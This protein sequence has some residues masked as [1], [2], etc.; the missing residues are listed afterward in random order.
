MPTWPSSASAGQES[1]AAAAAA[2]PR[3]AS[4]ARCAI[5]DSVPLPARGR[6]EGKRAAEE[7][8]HVLLEPHRDM[9]GVG[10]GIDLEVVLDAVGGEDVVKLAGIGLEVVLIPDVDRD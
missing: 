8:Q 1:I 9:A 2:R 7:R 6:V 3:L 5:A 4:V 10:A